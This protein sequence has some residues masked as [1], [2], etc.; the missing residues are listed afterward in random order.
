MIL[1]M[2]VEPSLGLVSCRDFESISGLKLAITDTPGQTV[3]PLERFV[4]SQRIED[5][6]TVNLSGPRHT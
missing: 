3:C 5:Q 6:W 1:K 2:Y 4:P